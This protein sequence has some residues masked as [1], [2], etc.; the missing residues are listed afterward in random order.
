MKRC[1]T[2]LRDAHIAFQTVNMSLTALLPRLQNSGMDFYLESSQHL[3]PSGEES[4]VIV[5]KTISDGGITIDFWF[6]KVHT[7]N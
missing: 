3:R 2:K 1:K 7:S 6:I 5:N 4:L